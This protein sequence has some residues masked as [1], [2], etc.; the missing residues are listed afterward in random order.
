M[1]LRDDLDAME[2]HRDAGT[3]HEFLTGTAKPLPVDP[4]LDRSAH[5]P[6]KTWAFVKSRND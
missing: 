4:P 5:A 3:L 1:S 2:R 6:R